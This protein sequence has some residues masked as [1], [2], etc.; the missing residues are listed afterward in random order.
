MKIVVFCHLMACKSA[1]DKVATLLIE[2]FIWR[3]NMF[4][5]NCGKPINDNQAI[6]LE[7]GVHNGVGN[8]Y[9][10]NCGSSINPGAAVCLNCGMAINT[11]SPIGAVGT[12][13]KLVTLLLAIFLGDFGIHNFYLGYIK[14]GILQLL[15]S[16]FLS[17]TVIVPVGIWIWA[18]V[19]GINAMQGSLPDANGNALRD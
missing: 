18:L 19:E 12:K 10:G 6:C 7:C 17:W 11:V 3:F 1:K 4:C 8:L 9:C 2:L 15:L 14:K 16:I 13:S 5:R